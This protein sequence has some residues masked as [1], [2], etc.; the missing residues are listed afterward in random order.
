MN[1]L[2]LPLGHP[3]L[4]TG[5]FACC[6]ICTARHPLQTLLHEHQQHPEQNISAP[7]ITK[8]SKHHL[9]ILSP[10]EKSPHSLREAHLAGT[11]PPPALLQQLLYWALCRIYHLRE[12]K[13]C[14]FSNYQQ[15]VQLTN[16]N[17]LHSGVFTSC[18]RQDIPLFVE[19]RVEIS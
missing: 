18:A 15:V 5:A 9:P 11:H 1:G 16:S 4:P 12:G 8:T 13:S 2:I 10:D 3:G 17:S 7:Q 6:H 19:I 14:L